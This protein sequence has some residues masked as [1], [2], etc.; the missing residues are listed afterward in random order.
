MF[1]GILRH[2][3]KIDVA[4]TGVSGAGVREFPTTLVV[5]KPRPLAVACGR[6]ALAYIVAAARG[7]LIAWAWVF[8]AAAATP[9]AAFIGLTI[10]AA[11]SGYLITLAV[12]VWIWI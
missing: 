6:G 9:L 12:A 2:L 11:V 7:T 1:E 3:V 8:S 4:V 10:G 5:C